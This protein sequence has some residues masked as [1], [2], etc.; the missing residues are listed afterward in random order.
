MSPSS[1]SVSTV[2][3][4]INSS[5]STNGYAP[6]ATTASDGV[7]PLQSSNNQNKNTLHAAVPDE[8]KPQVHDIFKK[9]GNQS[10]T[11]QG[12]E[13]LFDLLLLHP[14]LQIE[15]LLSATSPPFRAYIQKGLDK[16]RLFFSSP[17][18]KSTCVK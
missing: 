15:T 13:A 3:A 5:Q 12:L 1:G 8:L 14:S 10:T 11:M 4:P 16:V 18:S 6:E 9:I 2:T 7:Q 17:Q